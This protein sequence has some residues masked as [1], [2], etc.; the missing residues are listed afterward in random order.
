MGLS[1]FLICVCLFSAE[2][3]SLFACFFSIINRGTRRSENVLTSFLCSLDQIPLAPGTL[4]GSAV[5]PAVIDLEV[6]WG[7]LLKHH[8]CSTGLS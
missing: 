5:D 1:R 2:L 8:C 7:Q 4:N 6:Q 3:I